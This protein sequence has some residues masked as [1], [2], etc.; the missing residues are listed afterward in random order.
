MK[1]EF[2]ISIVIIFVLIICGCST[3][4]P[5]GSDNCHKGLK[6]SLAGGDE[7]VIQAKT[8]GTTDSKPVEKYTVIVKSITEEKIIAEDADQNEKEFYFSDIVT[9]EKD[10]VDAEKLTNVER[11]ILVVVGAVSLGVIY[12]AVG[13]YGAISVF[14]TMLIWM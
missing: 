5:V 7:I 8:R 9:I 14:S 10:K 3:M 2:P 11:G 13:A 1:P 12:F 6:D 4:Q